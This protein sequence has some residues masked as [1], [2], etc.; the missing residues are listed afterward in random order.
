MAALWVGNRSW[1]V[2]S[3]FFNFCLFSDCKNPTCVCD[4]EPGCHSDV[5]FM[6]TCSCKSERIDFK[7]RNLGLDSEEVQYHI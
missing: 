4:P 7:R 6:D 1:D 2:F 5:E 3:L